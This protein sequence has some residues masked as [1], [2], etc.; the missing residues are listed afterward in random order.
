MQ[1]GSDSSGFIFVSIGKKHSKNKLDLIPTGNFK[2][3][4]KTRKQKTFREV[5]LIFR[6]VYFINTILR[7]LANWIHTIIL[8]KGLHLKTTTTTTKTYFSHN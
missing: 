2:F 1:L 5:I 3:I 8:V 4:R 6:H 7:A